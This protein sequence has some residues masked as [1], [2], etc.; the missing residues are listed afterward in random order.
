M[1]FLYALGHK[2]YLT[3]RILED[4]D[5]YPRPPFKGVNRQSS[6]ASKKAVGSLTELKTQYKRAT[7]DSTMLTNRSPFQTFYHMQIHY[8]IYSPT[9]GPIYMKLCDLYN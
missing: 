1:R 6:I 9:S 5:N 4:K 7:R 2:G 3:G 8:S